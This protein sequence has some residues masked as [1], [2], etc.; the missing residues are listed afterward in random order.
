M[1]YLQ[2]EVTTLPNFGKAVMS[3]WFKIPESALTEVSALTDSPSGTFG[4]GFEGICFNPPLYKIIPLI[5]FGSVETGLGDAAGVDVQP[6][7]VGVD[8]SHVGDG[9]PARLVVNLQTANICS[10]N[11]TPQNP[12]KEFRPECYYM[13]GYGF[14]AGS[15]ALTVTADTWHHALISFDIS[16]GCSITFANVNR[17][18]PD[19]QYALSLGP[20][21]S[22]SFDD[23][24]KVNRSML[25]SWGI[26]V[27]ESL[28]GTT[29]QHIVPNGFFSIWTG[30]DIAS[31]PIE[32]STDFTVSVG[33]GS[34]ASLGNQI[35][36]P[37]SAAFV[38]NVYNIEMCELQIFTGVTFDATLEVNRRAFIKADGTPETDYSVAEL[39]LGKSPEI[40]LIGATNWKVGN[41]SG[42]LDDN[43]AKNDGGTINTSSSTS[44]DIS[45]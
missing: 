37:A 16:P 44:P 6:S 15:H 5:T 1:G 27:D 22:W 7:F 42:S 20:T 41:N 4:D 32:S 23:Q 12:N 11:K 3:L 10:F 19:L 8:C 2:I 29:N 17:S 39:L 30:P 18:P 25:P 24:G 36:I 31:V 28:D 13:N 43:F 14:T 34:I 45:P 21:F 38:D 33:A 35:G 9:Y 26:A 40:K